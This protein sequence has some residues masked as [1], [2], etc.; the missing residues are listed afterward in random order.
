MKK[1]ARQYCID[2]CSEVPATTVRMRCRVANKQIPRTCAFLKNQDEHSLQLEIMLNLQTLNLAVL[3][4]RTISLSRS[5]PILLCL[6]QRFHRL[7]FDFGCAYNLM[8][9][10]DTVR[11]K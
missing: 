9:T 7:T 4:M 3:W 6:D 8:A 2:D 5:R 10:S 11:E 1:I